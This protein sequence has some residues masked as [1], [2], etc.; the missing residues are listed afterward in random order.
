MIAAQRELVAEL[1][2]LAGDESP[3]AGLEPDEVG[4]A[5][6]GLCKLDEPERRE[7]YASILARAGATR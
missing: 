2:K 4:G 6:G 5:D 3:L 1:L 7:S